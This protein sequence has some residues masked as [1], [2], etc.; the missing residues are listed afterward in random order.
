MKGKNKKTLPIS[1]R[2]RCRSPS[3]HM[4]G[5]Q[6]K[7]STLNVVKFSSLMLNNVTIYKRNENYS[8]Y[9]QLCTK[10]RKFCMKTRATKSKKTC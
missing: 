2:E 7:C 5:K 9:G 1:A 10:M 3:N 4:L 6:K 8:K